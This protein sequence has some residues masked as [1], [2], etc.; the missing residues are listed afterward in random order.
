MGPV[1]FEKVGCLD[2][3]LKTACFLKPLEGGGGGGGGCIKR[4][5]HKGGNYY[6]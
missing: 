1:I 2:F 4:C 6:I 3:C 5:L